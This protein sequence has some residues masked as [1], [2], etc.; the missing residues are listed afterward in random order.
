MTAA[1]PNSGVLWNT[2]AFQF[3]E[4]TFI[5]IVDHSVGANGVLFR[6][7]PMT[8]GLRLFPTFSSIRFSVPGFTRIPLVHLEWSVV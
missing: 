5:V 4:F 7:S 6:K 8:T 2:E 1:F 3:L